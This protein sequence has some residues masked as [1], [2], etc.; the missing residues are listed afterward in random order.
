MVCN[1][2][3]TDNMLS[4][5]VCL[6][7]LDSAT[8]IDWLTIVVDKPLKSYDQYPHNHKGCVAVNGETDYF[9]DTR[10]AILGLYSQRG[11]TSYRKISWSLEAVRF[12]FKLFQSL[13]NLAGTSAALLPR[14]LSNFIAIR[15]LQHPIS[16]LRDFMRFGGKTSYRLVY[17]GPEIHVIFSQRRPDLRSS[18]W[19]RCNWVRGKITMISSQASTPTYGWPSN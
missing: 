18:N 6:P 17:R 3:C 16:R 19:H 9:H 2:G 5:H 8:L 14:C 15:P 11:K 1:V 4:F 13:W 7:F 10:V 12:G